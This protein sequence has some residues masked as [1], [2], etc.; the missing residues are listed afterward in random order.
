MRYTD[1]IWIS[2]N[3][4]PFDRLSIQDGFTH[5]FTPAAMVAWTTDVPHWSTDRT[6]DLRYRFLSAMQGALG[7][8]NN[9]NKWSDADFAVAA[10]MVADYK[11][12]RGTVQSG[13][14]FRLVRPEEDARTIDT[15]YV[16]ADH[17]RPYC[18]IWCATF[19]RGTMSPRSC[20]V[21][22]TRLGDTRRGSSGVDRCLSVYPRMRWGPI[23]WGRA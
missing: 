6:T 13:Q 16:A 1:Q 9:L 19:R 11:V 7:I 22:S 23:G 21:A 5:A 14:I 10:S 17:R 12:I 15:L 3:T 18:S 20:F 4:D 2:D 8:G